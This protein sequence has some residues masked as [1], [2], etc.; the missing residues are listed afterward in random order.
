MQLSIGKLTNLPR[1]LHCAMF[2]AQPEMPNCVGNGFV[3]TAWVLI[4]HKM[5]AQR[6]V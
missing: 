2:C 4:S 3:K 1:S 6:E 5:P